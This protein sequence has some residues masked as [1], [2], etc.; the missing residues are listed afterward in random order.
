MYLWD[1]ITAAELV[2]EFVD[3]KDFENYSNDALLRS[4]VE[5]QLEIAGEALNQLGKVDPDLAARIPELRSIVGFRNVLVHRYHGLD[6]GIVW[7]VTVDKM[8][9]L[10]VGL[11]ALLDELNE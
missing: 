8:P 7:S 3:G 6:N 10:L 2:N 9:E 1:A 4:A 11:Q 5:R